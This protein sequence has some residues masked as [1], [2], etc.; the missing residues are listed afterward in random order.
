MSG[1]S[2]Y[3]VWGD[4]GEFNVTRGDNV[5][6]GSKWQKVQMVRYL[7]REGELWRV[8]SAIPKCYQEILVNG[9]CS[10]S[11]DF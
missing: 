1:R 2:P 4:S 3:C 8:F 10:P 5:G 7:G 11:R 9:Q 6:Q